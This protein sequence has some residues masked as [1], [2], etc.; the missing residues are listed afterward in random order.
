MINLIATA[1]A[2]AGEGG[3]QQY[4]FV[5][6]IIEG[7]PVTWITFGVLLIMF[8]GSLYILFTK[9][10]EQNKVM[11]QGREAV[12]NFWRA[13][14]LAEGANKMERNSAFRQIVDDGLRALAS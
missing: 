12:A 9:L 11:R 10:F 5:Q 2:A 7:G 13:P 1:G 6:A 4:G 8:V 14:T 3:Q